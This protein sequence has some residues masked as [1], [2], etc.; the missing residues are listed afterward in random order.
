MVIWSGALPLFFSV[1]FSRAACLTKLVDG[2]A[3]DEV[4]S[5]VVIVVK[6]RGSD[7]TNLLDRNAGRLGGQVA[8]QNTCSTM[9]GPDQE[10]R[11]R[12]RCQVRC[13]G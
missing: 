13:G 10:Y 7:D 6:R 1:S 12:S 2:Q 4:G 9:S 3:K 8:V 5:R 11:H